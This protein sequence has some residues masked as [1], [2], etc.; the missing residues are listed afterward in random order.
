M[1]LLRACLLGLAT[2]SLLFLSACVNKEPQE[3]AAFIQLLQSRMG[4]ASLLPI[5][6]LSEPE[7]EAVGG[8]A[9][10]YE[11]ITDFQ[12]A[13]AQAAVSMRD[14]P[15]IETLRSVAEIVE[16]RTRFEAA[17]KTLA[18][19]AAEIQRAQ[20][21]ADKARAALALPPDLAPVY[22]GV[23][24]EAVTAPAAELLEAA[25]A[26][27]AVAR[28]ALGVADFVAAHAQDILLLDGQARVATLTL[29]QELNLR[30]Q[31]LNAQSQVLERA[32][33]TLMQLAGQSPDAR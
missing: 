18:E 28:D 15:E 19:Q 24:D 1:A 11:V 20:A 2:A 16:R 33:A 7:K 10:A 8:Y 4:S 26:M 22:D 9:E 30:L 29:L 14:V 13:L 12:E 31:G 21:K 32:R 25:A 5:G 17:R 6:V 3:R 27:D 23:Y